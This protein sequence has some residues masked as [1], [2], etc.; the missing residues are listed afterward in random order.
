[1]PFLGAA[2][3]VLI[4]IPMEPVAI[5]TGMWHWFGMPVPLQ[6]Y[7]AWYVV[8]AAILYILDRLL[9]ENSTNQLAGLLLGLQ[10]LFFVT[11]A[12]FW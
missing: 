8:A 11:L 4:D 12:I 5:K 10:F 2:V 7:I 1:L 3:L 6:N 9:P